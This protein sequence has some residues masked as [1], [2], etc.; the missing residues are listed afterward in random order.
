VAWAP[1]GKEIWYTGT[2]GDQGSTLHAVDLEGRSRIV[3]RSIGGIEL[4]D[5]AADGRVLLGSQKPER[6]VLALLEGYAEPR[7]LYVSGQSSMARG[8]TADGRAVLVA[9]HDTK[10]YESF[11]VRSDRPGAVK[12]SSGDC[13]GISPDRTLAMTTSADYRTLFLSPLGMGP[14]RA[15]PNPDRIEYQSLA[16]WLPDGKRFV[17]VGRQGD[18]PSRAFVCDLESGRG[19][20]FGATGVD[21]TFFTPLPVSP[22]GRFAVLQGADGIAKQ[23]PIEGGE[24]IPIPELHPED[25]P[26]TYTEDGKALF[27]AGRSVPVNIERLELETGDRTPWITVAPTDRAGLRYALA[28]ISPNGR[29][30]AMTTAKLLTDLYIV[31]GLR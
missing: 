25:Q 9:S 6:E 11:V 12:L 19:T 1:G 13:V 26:L 4:F 24:P 17:I 29:Y 21:W 23:W 30:W 3:Y 20:P 8:V 15:I 22:D 7:P 10:E 28:T 18:A 27:V 31:E 5:I 14:T 2:E 16:S